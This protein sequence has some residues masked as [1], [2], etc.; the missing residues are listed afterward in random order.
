LNS[1]HPASNLVTT[2]MPSQLQYTR[3]KT[4]SKRFISPYII[5]SEDRGICST[6]WQ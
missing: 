1:D 3:E 6:Q 5:H 4:Y 2:L